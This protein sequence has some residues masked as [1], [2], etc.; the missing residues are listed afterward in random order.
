MRATLLN[1]SWCSNYMLLFVGPVAQRLEQSAH[2]AL[3]GGSNPSGPTIF[4]PDVLPN[5]LIS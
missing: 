4:R 1:P 3:V 2:N 5:L